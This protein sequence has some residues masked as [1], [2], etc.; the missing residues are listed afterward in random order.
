MR[1]ELPKRLT[2]SSLST[3]QIKAQ[4]VPHKAH[5]AFVGSG[6][7]STQVQASRA[8]H[9]IAISVQDHLGFNERSATL[10]EL[11]SALRLGQP[12]R[13]S[14]ALQGQHQPAHHGARS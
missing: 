9:R 6:F 1:E 2:Y 7:I 3:L 13:S 10:G 4:P 5:S 11:R 8:R 14:Y 12:Q